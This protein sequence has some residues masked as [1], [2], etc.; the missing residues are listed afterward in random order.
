MVVG[1]IKEGFLRANYEGEFVTSARLRRSKMLNQLNT[2]IPAQIARQL[3][4]KKTPMQ[5]LQ[6]QLPTPA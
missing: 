3:T 5:Q 2:L 1:A 6:C 4:V